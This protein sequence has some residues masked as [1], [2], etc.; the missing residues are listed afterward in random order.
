MDLVVTAVADALRTHMGI[1][2]LART[3]IEEAIA[4]LI[5]AEDRMV[6][7]RLPVARRSRYVVTVSR[8]PPSFWRF[9]GVVEEEALS[10][11]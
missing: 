1:E 11:S 4:N 10:E 9:C 2:G 3:E 6:T 5:A 7:V 8:D